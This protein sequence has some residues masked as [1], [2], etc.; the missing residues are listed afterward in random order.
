MRPDTTRAIAI[1]ALAAVAT[2]ARA[3][4]IRTADYAQLEQQLSRRID[5]ERL[6]NRPEPGFNLDLPV[7]SSGA[8]LGERFHGQD[9]G[10][11]DSG[12]DR[13]L[14][15]PAGPFLKILGGAPGRNL[16]VAHHNGFGSNALFPLGA[17]GFPAIDARGEGALAILFD[18]DQ[19]AVGFRIH[20]EYPDPLGGGRAT[21]GSIEI[22][23]LARSGETL[24]V[25][26]HGTVPGVNAFGYRSARNL[27]EIAGLLILN[28]DPGGIAVDDIIFAMPPLLG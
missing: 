8:W 3:E 23:F 5:F 13:V 7:Y 18:S 10:T 24:G 4:G 16:S 26:T 2:G 15:H 9:L 20:A 12:H 25:L 19:T 28:T 11:S 6:P 17:A 27:P 1:L 14:G 21:V 22:R